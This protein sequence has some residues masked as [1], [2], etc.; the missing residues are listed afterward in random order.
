MEPVP[1]ALEVQSLNHW[2]AREV[3]LLQFFLKR[4]LPLWII[5]L[6][7]DMVFVGKESA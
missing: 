1:R 5:W 6:P 7:R 3:L 4:D 2:L